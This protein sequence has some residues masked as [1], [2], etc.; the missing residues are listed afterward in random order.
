MEHGVPAVKDID[1]VLHRIAD[2]KRQNADIMAERWRI[3]AI[4][5][6]GADGMY[7][8]MAWDFG[9]GASSAAGRD[10]ARNI[11]VDLPTVNLVAS[12]NERFATMLGRPPTLKAPRADDDKV[13]EI[14]RRYD[15]GESA[16]AIARELGL[17]KTQATRIAKRRA[18]R[19]VPEE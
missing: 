17:S 4:M 2:L 5:N 15:A 18:W 10:V 1:Y 16:A 8:V 6:G 14:R 19:H 12:G 7:A 9:K 11:G 3:R 13:R